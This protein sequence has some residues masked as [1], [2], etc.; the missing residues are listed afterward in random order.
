MS[1]IMNTHLGPEHRDG[2]PHSR[3][4]I[5]A[6]K[7]EVGFY[8]HEAIRLRDPIAGKVSSW[9]RRAGTI[10]TGT[11]AFGVRVDRIGAWLD[12]LP[13]A[14]HFT[15]FHAECEA[16]G[17]LA[18]MLP[19][20]RLLR[21]LAP[22]GEVEPPGDADYVLAYA[23]LLEVYAGGCLTEAAV[24]GRL[25]EAAEDMLAALAAWPCDRDDAVPLAT[26]VSIAVAELSLDGA[27]YPAPTGGVGPTAPEGQDLYSITASCPSDAFGAT[28]LAPWST[29]TLPELQACGAPVVRLTDD[30]VRH[31][32]ATG[33]VPPG[34]RV[35]ALAVAA[36]YYYTLARHSFGN[37]ELP[38]SH[39]P[40]AF[41]TIDDLV[42]A[43]LD[44]FP[45]R[46]REVAELRVLGA[47][48]RLEWFVAGDD[49]LPMGQEFL[50]GGARELRKAIASLESLGLAGTAQHAFALA[51]EARY[52]SLGGL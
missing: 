3:V 18:R 8:M 52:E 31:I 14:M 21:A 44:L 36:F 27:V 33:A 23:G 38:A 6:I 47:E 32:A 19:V 39:D 10:A 24:A 49:A 9:L 7:R 5:D 16:A 41:S 45:D 51:L 40:Y 28:P 13:R 25:P 37:P 11:A 29:S 22:F 15:D 4:L 26:L 48:T 50:E 43:L 2:H 35:H 46:L 34:L 42:V 1:E 30:G 20:F 17:D 12:F